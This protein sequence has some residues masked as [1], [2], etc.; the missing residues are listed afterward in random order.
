MVKNVDAAGLRIALLAYV[1]H[2]AL[3]SQT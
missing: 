3:G 1:M 2:Y